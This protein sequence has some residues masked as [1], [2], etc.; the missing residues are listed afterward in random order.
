VIAP[1][2]AAA[3][4]IDAAGMAAVDLREP[5]G[6][7]NGRFSPDRVRSSPGGN[8]VSMLIEWRRWFSSPEMDLIVWYGEGRSVAAFELYYDKNRAEH[9][10]I[11]RTGQ[12]FSHLAVDDGEQNPVF[13]Y[14]EAPILIPDGQFDL[15]RIREQFEESSEKLPADIAGLVSSKL[16]QWR[17]ARQQY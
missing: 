5:A 8:A 9:V 7:L 17:G 11:W 14:K 4:A 16:R 2:P 6:V 3:E 1:R 12:G 13:E 10:L 15:E